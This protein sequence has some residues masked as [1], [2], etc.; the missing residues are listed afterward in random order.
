MAVFYSGWVRILVR[1][2]NWV[3]D[4]V[5]SLPALAAVRARFP[6]AHIA[7]LARPWVAD[8]YRHEPFASGI[9]PY[10]PGGGW[11]GW[12]ARRTMANN[13]RERNFDCAL[14]LQNAF[15]AALIAWLAKIPRRIGYARDGRGLLLTDAIARPRRGALPPHESF[16]YLELLRSVGWVEAV[17]AEALIRLEG[18]FR[19]REAGA[20]RW[21]EEG[22]SGPVIGVSPGAAYGNAKRWLPERF[23][24]A[25]ARVARAAGARVALFGSGAEKDVAESIRLD[26]ENR[27][28]EARNFAGATSLG[29]FIERAAAC[30]LVLTNDSGAMHIASALE[31]PTV[32]VFGATNHITTGP[33][34]PWARIVRRDVECSPCLLRECPI[35]HRCMKAVEAGEVADV[36][37]ELLQRKGNGHA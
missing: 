25:A 33:T 24:E 27:G 12:R 4:A 26:L 14:L 20:R 31:V 36:A 30:S 8:L 13:L 22:W 21:A 34:G 32:T 18:R 16:Y 11:N 1:A 29:E 6:E 35:D 17:P 23:A 28:V 5:M 2:T 37:L 3:G 10:Q 15:D 19:A 9:I 7:V